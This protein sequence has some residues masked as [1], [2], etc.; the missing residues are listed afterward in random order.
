MPRC[1]GHLELMAGSSTLI[2]FVGHGTRV[3][4]GATEFLQFC[5][6][7]EQRIWERVNAKM[8][9]R[10]ERAFLEIAE[11]D[12]ASTLVRCC[13]DCVERVLLVP[14]FLFE[15]GHMKHDIPEVIAAVRP[16]I[17]VT[18]LELLPAIGVDSAFVDVTVERL[19]ETG[20][21]AESSGAPNSVLLLGRGNTDDSAQDDFTAFA[22]LVQD[23]ACISQLE[24]GYLAGSG[25]DW[26][27][28][29]SFLVKSGAETIC[30]QPYLW[31]HGWLTEQLSKW[32]AD[33][34]CEVSDS[35]PSSVNRLKILVGEPLG[36]HE[37]LV[38]SV[39]ERILKAL[40]HVNCPT[41]LVPE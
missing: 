36:V 6:L 41:S 25:R 19:I 16:H 27:E 8:S 15:A 28:S 24:T 18:K 21:V 2:L 35:S 39:A 10:F 11:P 30:I 17:G 1:R 23:R 32:I 34:R 14:L 38:A 31:F 20:Y 5:R 9:L 33:W 40:V 26:R 3:T 4:A 13:A 12:L 29:L 22:K 37:A 7:V